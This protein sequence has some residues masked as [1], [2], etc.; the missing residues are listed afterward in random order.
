M[1]SYSAT[2]LNTAFTNEPHPSPPEAVRGEESV[3]NRLTT[4]VLQRLR[5]ALRDTQFTAGSSRIRI[6]VGD[7]ASLSLSDAK[8]DLCGY[9]D[10]DAPMPR[11]PGDIKCSWKWHSTWQDIAEEGKSLEFQAP[12]AQLNFYMNQCSSRYGYILT[13]AEVVLFKK[14]NKHPAAHLYMAPAIPLTT[15]DHMGTFSLHHGH[16]TPLLALWYIHMLAAHDD[17]WF[18]EI[19]SDE[20]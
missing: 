7:V 14:K 4:L 17:K 16:L 18:V 11:I 2:L 6:D 20:E 8:P 13:D 3:K 5:R 15:F 1:Q 19:L 9:T 10:P 12:V